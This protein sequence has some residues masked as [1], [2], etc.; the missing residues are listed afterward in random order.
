MP[1]QYPIGLPLPLIMPYSN[2]EQ[3]AVRHDES[4]LG[5]PSYQLLSL[6]VPTQFNA[7][8]SFTWTDLQ[9][10]EAWYKHKL[11]KNANSFNIDL[12][13]GAGQ[14]THECNFIGT[15]NAT[16]PGV[17]KR[18]R[19]SSV[20]RAIE[21]QYSTESSLD[22]LLTW[23]EFLEGI[24]DKGSVINSFLQFSNIDLPDAWENLNYG[25]TF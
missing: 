20:L 3:E 1:E 25:T 14:V 13:V 4:E 23:Y 24:N 21:K 19:V 7:E 10:F 8:F 15:P 17:S 6:D 22:D 5:P 9:V 16:R 12:D 11:L 2:Q 18:W